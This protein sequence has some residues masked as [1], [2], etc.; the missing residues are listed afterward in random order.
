MPRYIRIVGGRQVEV[1][2]VPEGR[3]A[4]PVKSAADIPKDAFND[5]YYAVA[6]A[7]ITPSQGA[8][9]PAN[10]IPSQQRVSRPEALAVDTTPASRWSLRVPGKATAATQPPSQAVQK[11]LLPEAPKQIDPTEMN[12]QADHMVAVGMFSG[13]DAKLKALASLGSG[14]AVQQLKDKQK[15]PAK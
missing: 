11:P 5:F 4:H 12:A 13:P 3:E 15:A 1:P 7:A 14:W 8:G 10:A 2:G 9:V 6:D